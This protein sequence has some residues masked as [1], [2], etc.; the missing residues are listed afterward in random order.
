MDAGDFFED[1]DGDHD[2]SGN[3]P[4][5]AVD[6]CSFLEILAATLDAYRGEPE[7]LALLISYL[8]AS[9]T[10][11]PCHDAL[12]FLR[13]HCDGQDDQDEAEGV[14]ETDRDHE[15][16]AS[17]DEFLLLQR[18]AALEYISDACDIADPSTPA[19]RKYTTGLSLHNRASLLVIFG[20]MQP[21]T[22]F[23]F[24]RDAADYSKQTAAAL[25]YEMTEIKIARDIAEAERTKI[26]AAKAE[27]KRLKNEK[28][29]AQK[30]RSNN[31]DTSSTALGGAAGSSHSGCVCPSSDG[32]GASDS[33]AE[34]YS[35][36]KNA[37]SVES[38][39]VSGTAAPSDASPSAS[40][41][42]NVITT[43]CMLGGV[44]GSSHSGCVCP[45][46]DGLGAS[47]STAEA[48]SLLKN[49]KSVESVAVSGTTAPSDV[50]SSPNFAAS[51]IA[52]DPCVSPASKTAANSASTVKFFGLPCDSSHASISKSMR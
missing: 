16:V 30:A 50:P 5:A 33:T 41:F 14:D 34:A 10:L 21:S 17:A 31:E 37:K 48:Y 28:K 19:S 3:I 23:D 11:I 52:A 13:R 49:A 4:A 39:A 40:L 20:G 22:I 42:N 44:A 15:S 32:L 12:G 1:F 6:S 43:G 9:Q 38:V 8:I 25:Q 45:S 24:A 7:T 46:S 18:R 2:T 26:E 27:A 51:T 47:D 36:L 29:R 35:L